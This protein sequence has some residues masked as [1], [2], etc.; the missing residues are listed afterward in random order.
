MCVPAFLYY[1][2]V[3]EENR[4]LAGRNFCAN[5]AFSR[6]IA[7]FRKLQG[8]LRVRRYLCFPAKVR[9][10]CGGG[11]HAIN[12]CSN[13]APYSYL[14]K[15]HLTH[16]TTDSMCFMQTLL[17]IQRT[18]LYCGYHTLFIKQNRGKLFVATT[19]HLRATFGQF[20]AD[21]QRIFQ[22]NLCV[23]L[24]HFQCSFRANSA[25]IFHFYPAIFFRD[26]HLL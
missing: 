5:F 8:N 21:F 7:I 10:F 17:I 14:R 1:H 9:I 25:Q 4:D 13:W 23:I 6:K 11:W 26:C 3:P 24:A 15:I 18:Q 19:K 22:L 16:N 20:F 2:S 12:F